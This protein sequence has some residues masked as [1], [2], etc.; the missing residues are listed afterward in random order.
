MPKNAEQALSDRVRGELLRKFDIE[1]LV[2]QQVSEVL[3]KLER[4]I[5]DLINIR[6]DVNQIL[7]ED[8]RRAW[9]TVINQMVERIIE[10][11]S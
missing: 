4:Y 11:I 5:Y 8:T 7:N 6:G 10:K 2:L 3:P 9:K 1:K